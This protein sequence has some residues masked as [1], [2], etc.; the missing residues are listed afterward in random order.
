MLWQIWNVYHVE[1]ASFLQWDQ[2]NVLDVQ[3]KN[4]KVLKDMTLV[5]VED[6]IVNSFF[7]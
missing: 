7:L 4:L 2:T 1:L 5:A 3:E 6:T